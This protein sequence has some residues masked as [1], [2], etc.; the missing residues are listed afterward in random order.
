M[1]LKDLR[2]DWEIWSRPLERYEIFLAAW[3]FLLL[4]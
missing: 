3:V 1:E 2:L 4:V